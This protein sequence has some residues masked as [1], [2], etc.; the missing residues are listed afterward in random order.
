MTERNEGYSVED[1]GAGG[2]RGG[3]RDLGVHPGC[4]S[5]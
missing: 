1:E 3:T 2:G 5:G 4:D